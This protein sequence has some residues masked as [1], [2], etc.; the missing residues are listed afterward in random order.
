[1]DNFYRDT[2]AE[3]N[4][5]NIYYNVNSIVNHVRQNN[6][7]LERVYAVVKAN[8][9]GHGDYMVAKTALEAGANALAVTLLDEGIRMR[10]LFK[11]IPILVMGVVRIEDFHLVNKYNLEINIFDYPYL[12]QAM[13]NYQ[14]KR[15]KIHLKIDSGMSRLGL[16]NIEYIDKALKMIKKNP[17]FKLKGIFTHFHSAD[18]KNEEDFLR[19]FNHFNNILGHLKKNG[20]DNVH[21]ANSATSIRYAS[22]LKGTNGIRLGISMYG[23]KP[24][25]DLEWEIPLKPALSWKTKIAQIKFLFK[26]ETVSYGATYTADED[27]IIAILPIGYADGLIR[28][29]QRRNVAI[30]GNLY[31]II[32]RVCMGLTMVLVDTSIKPG[33]VVEIIGDK[34]TADDMARDLNTIN[35]EVTCLISDRVPR[36]YYQD[37]KLVNIVNSRY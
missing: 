7:E 30:N 33:D 2:W 34:I 24:N 27:Q 25:R 22:Y 1:M 19:Q 5:D 3:I 16:K 8:A 36:V 10:K 28:A 4:L 9:Y 15:I 26:G 31:P 32:G 11:K 23:L 20:Y 21:I 6:P 29:N 14:G 12:V 37:N 13:E 35:Y 17:L 18:S